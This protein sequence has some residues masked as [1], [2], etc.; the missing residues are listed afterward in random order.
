[1]TKIK[2]GDSFRTINDAS[3]YAFGRKAP[4]IGFKPAA[5]FHLNGDYWA[6]FSRNSEGWNDISSETEIKVSHKKLNGEKRIERERLHKSRKFVTFI[7]DHIEKHYKFVGVYKFVRR[8][9]NEF[10]Y[11]RTSTEYRSTP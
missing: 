11:E 6:W 10:I 3:E 1:M 7:Y 5:D 2:V 4:I 8:E 9:G